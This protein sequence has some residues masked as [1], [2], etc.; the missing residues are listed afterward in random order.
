MC[1]G[2]G[3]QCKP[4]T[5]SLADSPGNILA[6]ERPG[7][8]FWEDTVC[9]ENHICQLTLGKAPRNPPPDPAPILVG[10]LDVAVPGFYHAPGSCMRQMRND[11]SPC[12]VS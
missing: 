10:H 8:E 6:P 11:S 7:K 12:R 1:D 4:A 9:H 5:V 2:Q 3:H